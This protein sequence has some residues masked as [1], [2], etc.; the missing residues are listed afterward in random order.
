MWYGD[1]DPQGSA[2]NATEDSA[3]ISDQE[4]EEEEEE[5]EEQ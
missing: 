1:S 2:D 4:E 5:E 3:D